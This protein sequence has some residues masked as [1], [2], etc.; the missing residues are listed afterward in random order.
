[1][2]DQM[3][4]QTVLEQAWQRVADRESERLRDLFVTQEAPVQPARAVLAQVLS[5]LVL[6]VFGLLTLL[7]VWFALIVVGRGHANVLARLMAFMV[8]APLLTFAW[9]AWPRVNRLDGLELTPQDT[10]ELHTLVRRV[11]QDMGVDRPVRVVLNA[12]MNAFMG[13]HGWR[14]QPTL[15]LGLGLWYALRPQERVAVIAHELAHLKNGDPTRQ[16]A[17]WAALRVLSS[18]VDGLWPDPLMEAQAGLIALTAMMITKAVALLPW[19][20]L[21]L[22]LGLVGA[23]QQAAEY[24]ADLL[25]SRVA[26]SAPK[27][28]A[29][30]KLHLGH[31]LES[32]LHKQRMMPERPHAFAELQ[33]MFEHLP[34]AQWERMRA[35][36]RQ[37]RLRLDASH[38]PTADRMQV[39]EAWPQPGTVMLSAEQSARLDA[40]LAPF[41]AVLEREALEEH[42][43][44]VFG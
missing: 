28:A 1:M 37:D 27:R 29:L 33:H 34:E 35:R 8:A 22:L 43:D 39:V 6:V 41:V 2:T 4:P 32:A 44:R 11:S 31:L 38:P 30:D 14:R 10:P 20:L 42:R 15:G 25:A 40:E 23:D 9:I 36:R 24:R 21:Q 12:D 17:V 7:G 5:V 16:G 13:M 26:G 19:G 18:A 3:Q